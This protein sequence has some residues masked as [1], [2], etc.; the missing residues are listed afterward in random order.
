MK[1]KGCGREI[2]GECK[3]LNGYCKY[4]CIYGH[5]EEVKEK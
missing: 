5:Y 3:C 2:K 1:C 4:C